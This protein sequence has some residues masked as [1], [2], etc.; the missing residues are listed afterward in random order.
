MWCFG[1]EGKLSPRYVGPF[2]VVKPMS[3]LAYKI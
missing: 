3:P 1:K 2:Q